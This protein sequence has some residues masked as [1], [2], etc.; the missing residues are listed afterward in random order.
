[1]PCNREWDLGD[2]KGRGEKAA[3]G[4]SNRSGQDEETCLS[5]ATHPLWPRILKHV[6]KKAMRDPPDSPGPIGLGVGGRKEA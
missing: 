2:K 5:S 3:V 4:W 6:Y 1:M